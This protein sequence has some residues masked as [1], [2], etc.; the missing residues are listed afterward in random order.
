MASRYT[1]NKEQKLSDGRK[2]FRSKRYPNIPKQNTDIYVVTQAGDRLDELSNQFYND[3]SLWWIIATANNIHDA[4]LTV[5]DGT[6][7]RIPVD[8][9]NIINEF[10]D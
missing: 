9:N 4:S 2:V 10:N 1:N 3:S 6:V 5:D 8:Y 7:L